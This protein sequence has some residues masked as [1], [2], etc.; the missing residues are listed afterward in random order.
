MPNVSEKK[1]KTLYL[2][3]ILLE[4]TDSQH[5]LTLPQMLE[6]LES[7]GVS[8]ERKSIYDD[9]ETLRS[10]GVK[11]ETRKSRTFQYYV[12]ARTFSVPEIRLIE[13]A[14]R[15]ARFISDEQV[16]ELAGKLEGLCSA[17]Q[18]A[19]LHRAAPDSTGSEEENAADGAA[20]LRRAIA[21]NRQVSFQ[22]LE[23]KLSSDHR[24]ERGPKK[25][26]KTLTVSPW[27]IFWSRDHYELTAYDAALKKVRRFRMDEIASPKL[28]TINREGGDM[29]AVPETSGHSRQE[30]KIVLEFPAE[31]LGPVAEHFGPGFSAEPVGKNRLRAALQAEVGPE[32]FSWLFSYGTEIKLVSPKKLAERFRERA[33]MVAKLYKN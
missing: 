25:G 14:L 9:I 16:S 19:E 29:A 30:E 15:S 10:M 22:L 24:P 13:E 12:A 32:F 17:Y 2:L 18:A 6:E 31:F 8:A 26:G 4:K 3:K 23:W 28:L 5:A 20:I 27:K 1:K 11:I 7:L 21:E 33:K